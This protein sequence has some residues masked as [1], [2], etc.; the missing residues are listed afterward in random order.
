M[1]ETEMLLLFIAIFLIIGFVVGTLL[2]CFMK[3]EP[4]TL[5]L[6][7]ALVLLVFGI[8]FLG[9]L[10]DIA[11]QAETEIEATTEI[12]KKTKIDAKEEAKTIGT[13]GRGQIS[14]VLD[15]M[16]V[17]ATVPGFA[18]T[19]VS[20]T[21]IDNTKLSD[22]N[23]Q[24]V[25]NSSQEARR[26]LARQPNWDIAKG[27]LDPVLKRQK[28]PETLQGLSNLLSS[29]YE[30]CTQTIE[31]SISAE[32]KFCDGWKGNDN[33]TC[34]VKVQLNDEAEYFW[35]CEKDEPKVLV[36]CPMV[37]EKYCNRQYENQEPGALLRNVESFTNGRP[38]PFQI[39]ANGEGFSIGPRGQ[40]IPGRGR[41]WF[42]RSGITFDLSERS[43]DKISYFKL[44]YRLWDDY[45]GITVNGTRVWGTTNFTRTYDQG[46]VFTQRSEIDILPHLQAGSNTITIHGLVVRAGNLYAEFL[47][48][49]SDCADFTERWIE[50]CPD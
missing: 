22:A 24:S 37:L 1:M 31:P 2:I 18:G 35:T 27:T 42:V 12:E 17:P 16:P 10:Q 30:D 32:Q 46:R 8:G 39:L 9:V 26:V 21:N 50:T 45:M 15:T 6:I 41:R 34:E 11:A 38:L 5:M 47:T 19:S 14:T 33:E 28:N 43:F 4:S 48:S 44:G 25:D 36:T 23:E 40:L 49:F 13:S 7:I 3:K 29:Q 20:Q